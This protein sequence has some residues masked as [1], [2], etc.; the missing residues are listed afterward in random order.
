[1]SSKG[2][3][4]KF[5]YGMGVPTPQLNFKGD[6]KESNTVY[7][8]TYMYIYIYRIYIDIHPYIYIYISYI[9]YICIYIYDGF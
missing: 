4:R 7:R 5:N 8:Y 6:A 1:M 2:S 3:Q 9:S